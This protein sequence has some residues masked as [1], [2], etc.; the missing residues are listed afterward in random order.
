MPR[1]RKAL[2]SHTDGP[3]MRRAWN[4]MHEELVADE[5]VAGVRRRTLSV[6]SALRCS[7]LRRWYA[8]TWLSMAS[9]CF[10]AP[11]AGA[12]VLGAGALCALLRP[13]E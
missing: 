4:V 3:P 12:R 11:P 2:G 6:S 9:R 5:K 13:C 1:H 10:R 7:G 8:L